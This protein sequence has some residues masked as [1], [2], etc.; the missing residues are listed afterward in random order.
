VHSDVTTSFP[1][2]SSQWKNKQVLH[3]FASWTNP[4][5]APVPNQFFF[6]WKWVIESCTCVSDGSRWS[7]AREWWSRRAPTCSPQKPLR[8]YSPASFISL[9]L[10]L[11]S[12]QLY[13]SQM[14]NIWHF[15]WFN[16]QWGRGLAEPPFICA[17]AVSS[18]HNRLECD[19]ST[20]LMI[21]TCLL[22]SGQM[23][24][25]SIST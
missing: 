18:D 16:V 1:G 3:G 14:L 8:V 12:S 10:T 2:R 21:I 7:S 5:P 15:K 22:T 13:K 4:E 24:Y 11:R 20:F 6:R 17:R 23:S 19:I 25:Y 9:C